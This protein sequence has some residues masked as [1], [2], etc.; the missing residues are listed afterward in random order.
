M[1]QP[2]GS[3][4]YSIQSQPLRMFTQLRGVYTALQSKLRI[5]GI[6]IRMYYYTFAYYCTYVC[7]VYEWCVFSVHIV[8][9]Q[10][11]GTGRAHSDV[12][13][14]LPKGIPCTSMP[15]AATSVQIKKRTS[16]ALNACK[17]SFLSCGL[18]SP[19]RQTQEYSLTTP[20][21]AHNEHGTLSSR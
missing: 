11:R 2:V 13:S 9:F 15:L 21:P 8:Y 7:I 14:P 6:M 1:K 17:L 19:W 20:R 12:V 10:N 16:P 18:R 5:N 3:G 4:Q